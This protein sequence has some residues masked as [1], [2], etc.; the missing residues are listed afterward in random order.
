M[1]ARSTR[2]GRLI[3]FIL[4]L[5]AASS[6]AG[7]EGALIVTRVENPAPM[8]DAAFGRS[9]AGLGDVDGDGWSDLAV[10]APGADIAYILSGHAPFDVIHAIPDPD[11]LSD[12]N[13][14]FAVA[15][16]GDL[17]GDGV[18]DLAVGAPG[19][20]ISI[21][22]PCPVEPPPCVANPVNGRAFAFSGS[23]GALIRNFTPAAAEGF[24]EFGFAVEGLGDV[25]GDGIPDVAVGSPVHHLTSWGEVYAFSG[26]DAA[27]LWRTREPPYPD[28]RQDIPSFGRFLASIEDLDGD[29]RRDLIVAAPFHDA[30]PDPVSYQLTGRTHI[31]SGDDGTIIRIDENPPP[32][33]VTSDDFFGGQVAAVGD[34]DGDGHEDYGA[35]DRGENAVHILSG[36]DGSVI[37][38][39]G[40]AADEAE[41][42][43]FALAG[44]G[45]RDG[46][47]LTDTWIGAPL[48]GKVI[49]A[50]SFG[51]TLAEHV[52]TGSAMGGFGFDVSATGD[53]SGDGTPDLVAGEPAATGPVGE[54][55]SGAVHVIAY[56]P[57]QPPV[58]DAGIDQTLSAGS[59]CLGSVTLDGTG[60]TDPD[61]DSLDFTWTSP[62]GTAV[63]PAPMVTLPLGTH[64]ITLT[65]EDDF[66]ETSTDTVE[67]TI[68]DTTGPTISSV[69]PSPERLW[70]PDHT[71]VPVNVAIAAVDNCDVSPSCA[72]VSVA[73]NEPIDGLGD[74]HTQ[75]DWSILGPLALHLRA[76]RSGAGNGRVYAITV[77]CTDT[78]Q[79]SSTAT[80]AVTVPRARR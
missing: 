5:L 34:Q 60:S 47:A 75:P 18:G 52:G 58:A 78:S 64:T 14:G 41:S 23:T 11:G 31:L 43:H 70:P 17:D 63:G 6:A 71:L 15:A 74:G 66:G 50:G 61:G 59:D 12:N 72:I 27:Q 28:E 32:V 29:G 9:V 48:T 62:F 7:A 53:L 30:D 42:G 49:L 77:G 54:T 45:D 19:D 65:V 8:A 40:V 56:V 79:N 24:L 21:P 38:S 44:A 20:L 69:T 68:V 25:T 13:F 37:R 1:P 46:D 73:S 4:C 3:G 35:G 36:D 33:P 2:N 26:A 76:E 51:E 55:G 57:N 67:V 80:G 22:L 39:I 16:V 10:G